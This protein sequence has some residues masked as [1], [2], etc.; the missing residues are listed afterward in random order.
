MRL[1]NTRTLED[2]ITMR[3]KYTIPKTTDARLAGASIYIQ[4]HYESAQHT[5]ATDPV[6]IRFIAAED[7]NSG[8]GGTDSDGD[9]NSG[10]TDSN[11]DT[12]S[13]GTDTGGDG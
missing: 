2:A 12:N 8:S 10:G 5:L 7:T 9:T 4:L 13:G 6:A 11:G 1:E 3:Q